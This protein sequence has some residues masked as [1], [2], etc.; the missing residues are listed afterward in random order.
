MPGWWDED[1]IGEGAVKPCT[2]VNKQTN[3]NMKKAIWFS[4]HQ[5]TAKQLAEIAKL[6]FELVQTN[7]LTRM[8]GKSLKTQQQVADL[9]SVF[10]HWRNSGTSAVF[11]VFATPVQ[12][13]LYLYE[14]SGLVQL[15]FYS[16]WNVKR[17]PPGGKPTFQHK[18]FVLVGSV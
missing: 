9:L 7:E 14:G 18:K 12:S 11:G 17:T 3:K 5:P 15:K 16:A 2:L 1:L 13:L 6:G 8:A 4:R 10:Y